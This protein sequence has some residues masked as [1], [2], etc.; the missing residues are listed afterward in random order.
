[1]FFLII[2]YLNYYYS[3]TITLKT[4]EWK[5]SIKRRRDAFLGQGLNFHTIFSPTWQQCLPRSSMAKTVSPRAWSPWKN[6][7]KKC[8]IMWFSCFQS[9]QCAF[10]NGFLFPQSFIDSFNAVKKIPRVIKVHNGSI[11]ELIP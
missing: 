10:G 7:N 1:M 3:T 9:V 6:T 11:I 2:H 5:W 8:T 4:R